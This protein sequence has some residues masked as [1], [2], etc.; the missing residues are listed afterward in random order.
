MNENV[1]E[2]A[3]VT[4]ANFVFG[5]H[6]DAAAARD[7]CISLYSW[8]KNNPCKP[9][10]INQHS[11]GGNIGDAELLYETYTHLRSL[12]HHL[13]I[14]IH[15]RAT[16]CSSWVVQAADVRVMGAISE[17]CIHEVS[18]KAEGPYSLMMREIERVRHL[19]KKTFAI[20]CSR[21]A[22]TKTAKTPLTVE[23]IGEKTA[24]GRDWW[25]TAEEA[26]KYGLID[27]I[28]P[29]PAYRDPLPVTGQACASAA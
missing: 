2:P 9:L 16:S 29:V 26:L 8:S 7:F 27:A 23:I 11:T 10:R 24:E 14:A 12:G 20:T 18:S 28:E 22:S 19:Q 25:L 5:L 1:I 13:T 17:I 21:T 6:I 15:G 3:D 4:T